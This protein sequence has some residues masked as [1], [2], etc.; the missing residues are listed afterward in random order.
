MLISNF[1]VSLIH[2]TGYQLSE[3]KIPFFGLFGVCAAGRRRRAQAK[4]GIA[5][6]LVE[7]DILRL[8][9]VARGFAHGFT[10]QI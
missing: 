4:G 9:L 10:R 3:L 1:G 6:I 5:R 7:E 2:S 8:G